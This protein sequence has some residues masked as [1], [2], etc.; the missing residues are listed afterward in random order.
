MQSFT[1]S[2]FPVAFCRVQN[3]RGS[4]SQNQRAEKRDLSFVC[5]EDVIV[6]PTDIRKRVAI[7]SSTKEREQ[8]RLARTKVGNIAASGRS[9]LST[10]LL[11]EQLPSHQNQAP[12]PASTLL[13]LSSWAASAKIIYCCW[14][15]S[16]TTITRQILAKPVARIQSTAAFVLAIDAC[17]VMEGDFL[18]P[19]NGK[20]IKSVPGCHPVLF[21]AAARRQKV[22]HC[23]PKMGK[24]MGE[25]SPWK[26]KS[27]Y[28]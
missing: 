5:N 1:D 22:H 21:L 10:H 27:A 8:D 26:H 2:S 6:R 4:H 18:V 9:S 23:V 15:E 14:L 3:A 20:M 28:N 16:E 17:C 13:L 19:P 11:R 12:T 7:K 24:T 25:R